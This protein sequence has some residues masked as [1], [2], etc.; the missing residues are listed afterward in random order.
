MKYKLFLLI[1]FMAYRSFAQKS[2]DSSLSVDFCRQAFIEQLN[3]F[4]QEKIYVH[5]D[6][7]NYVAGDTIWFKIYLTDAVVHLP[8][9]KSRF[10]YI[11]LISPLGSIIKRMKVKIGKEDSHGELEIPSSQ[12]E[13]NY[14]IRA[15]TGMMYGLPHSNFFNKDLY[16]A[17]STF[18]GIKENIHYRFDKE[19]ITASFYF[20][21]SRSG[22]NIPVN[23]VQVGINDNAPKQL[24]MREGYGQFSFHIPDDSPTRIMHLQFDYNNQL[25]TK[26]VTIPYP[27]GEFHVA[28]FPEGGYLLSGKKCRVGIK[29]LKSNG[30]SEQVQGYVLDNEGNSIVKGIQTLY[31]GIGSFEFTPETGKS[32]SATFINQK[33]DQQTFPLPKVSDNALSLCSKWK[34]DKLYV[35][36][37][38]L[39]DHHKKSVL[40]LLI[41]SRGVTYYAKKWD[42]DTNTLLFPK[43]NFPSGVIE[44]LLL[45]K[46]YNPVSKRLVFCDNKDQASVEL[47][48][49]TDNVDGNEKVKLDISVSNPTSSPL[50]G[51]FSISVTNEKYTPI[52]QNKNILTYLLLSSDIQG[53]IEEPG[54][55]FQ[56]DEPLALL[57]LDNLMLT[58][59]WTRYE[60]PQVIKGVYQESSGFV[61]LGQ[62][63][64][65][66]VKS[67][68]GRKYKDNARVTMISLDNLFADETTTDKNGSFSFK[69]IDFKNNT[70]FILQAYDKKGS[71][72]VAIAVN[73]DEYPA[74]D[75]VDLFPVTEKKMV[76]EL[77]LLDNG[78]RTI[79]LD[80]VEVSASKT[81]KE[82][83]VYS[84]LADVSFDRK[85]IEELDA[86]CVHELLR[87]IPGLQLKGDRVIIRGASSIYGHSYA[88]IAIDGVIIDQV[89]A[90]RENDLLEF[91]LDH[92]SMPDIERVDVFKGGSA[93]IWGAKGGNGV[94]SFTTKRGNFD[95]SAI[96]RVRYNTKKIRPLGYKIPAEF[97]VPKYKT[98][99]IAPADYPTII[100]MPNVNSNE[101]GSASIEFFTPEKDANYSISIQGITEE[102]LIINSYSRLKK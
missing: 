84:K 2:P 51:N 79:L 32:Y 87:R 69:G 21:D 11:E 7:S 20:T 58:Q 67:V 64:S 8:S 10:A 42:S 81:E 53:N 44:I 61:E 82:I 45:D 95:Y 74:V 46:S 77:S 3:L 25:F 4:P 37:N 34:G 27:E 86:V 98:N 49:H 54:F 6:R 85:K 92:I 88:A 40:Y 63:I 97:Y 48:P 75:S 50:K 71:S 5:T 30:L 41:H 36:V 24:K 80:E 15:Y 99:K 70:E 73:E 13:G 83:P 100:W 62:E 57:A 19:K 31:K 102:G 96:D 22:E 76:E 33:G 52:D 56:A 59:G 43:Q 66:T 17:A 60:I 94:V 28:F 38:G 55:Y 78:V 35:S 68:S 91:D 47:I 26:Y 18:R 14:Y 72:H 1:L 16:I 23:M 65:G 39:K 101:K 9:K 12:P 93:V 90:S 89:D 29:A